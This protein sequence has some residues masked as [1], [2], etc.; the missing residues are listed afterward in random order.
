MSTIHFAKTR[1]AIPGTPN[2]ALRP[3]ENSMMVQSRSVS[4]PASG[5]AT[6]SFSV[7][8][9]GS[10]TVTMIH[11]STAEINDIGSRLAAARANGDLPNTRAPDYNLEIMYQDYQ[12]LLYLQR[13]RGDTSKPA[14]DEYS[15]AFVEVNREIVQRDIQFREQQQKSETSQRMESI[16][17]HLNEQVR[18]H[19][20]RQAAY[21]AITAAVTNGKS[22]NIEASAVMNEIRA[23]VHTMAGTQAHGVNVDNVNSVLEEVFAT[24]ETALLDAAGPLRLTSNRLDQNNNRYDQNNSRLGNQIDSLGTQVGALN[25]N[26]G[27]VSNHVS[28]LGALVHSVNTIA[29]ST[30][31]QT[32]QLSRDIN[33]LQEVI[34]MIPT[35]VEESLQRNLSLAIQAAMG[36]ALIG[37]LTTGLKNVTTPPSSP[38]SGHKKQRRGFFGFFKRS[39]KGSSVCAV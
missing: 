32:G 33:T 8:E 2:S 6:I 23:A 35:L 17:E 19:N 21:E 1:A 18:Q 11:L 36:P 29:N 20:A 15:A 34:N 10:E 13:L 16:R 30:N 24:I 31:A 12:R 38:T 27:A 9:K 26:V 37:A 3:Q 22:Q 39:H 28:A 14:S 4:G 25:N 5:S 7:Q